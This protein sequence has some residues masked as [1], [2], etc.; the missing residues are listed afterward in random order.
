MI[1]CVPRRGRSGEAGVAIPVFQRAGEDR[2]E[3]RDEVHHR[4]RATLADHRRVPVI[5]VNLSPHGLMAR[6]DAEIAVGEWITIALPAVG[7]VGAVVR[8]SLGGRIGCQLEHPIAAREY[9]ALLAA[10]C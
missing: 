6:T 4:T 9:G 7:T 5:V 10:A 8:W 3:P 1:R 2:T